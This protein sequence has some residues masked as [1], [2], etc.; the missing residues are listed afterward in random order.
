MRWE[1]PG[2]EFEEIYRETQ[3][4]YHEK[5][6][7]IYGAGMMGGRIYDAIVRVSQISVVAYLDRDV[8]KKE[9][10]GLPVFH[11]QDDWKKFGEDKSVMI[12]IALPDETGADVKKDLISRCGVR[13]D[14]CKLYSEFVMHDFPILMLYQNNKVFL[15]TVSLIVTE[16]CTLKCKHCAIMLPYFEQIHEYSFQKLADETDALFKNVDFIGNYTLTGGEPFLYKEL[17]RL[18]QYTGERY[19]DRIGSFK[20]ITNGTIVPGEEMLGLMRRFDMAV[21][22]SDY[23]NGVPALKPRLE[24]VLEVL[25]SSEIKTYLLSSSKWV[26]FGFNT[27]DHQYSHGQ[28]RDFFDYCHTRC[29]GYVDGK[30][31][32]CI[33]A[34]FAERTLYEKEDE[35]NT[36]DIVSGN[37]S[38]EW[39]RKLVE[40][41]LGYNSEG[42]LDMCQHC[43]G[44]VEVNQHYI[45]VGEQWTG[46]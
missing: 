26:D 32:Y 5:R 11:S 12:L 43:N 20:I 36:F 1:K 14:S 39:R 22:I 7:V 2:H 4:V 8:Q 34:Y 13:S 18:I 35:K 46:R 37:A 3:T 19:R 38:K 29:R 33:N 44:T 23:T 16:Q 10:R 15:D 17:Y 25:K 6:M 24:Q 28:L 45:E 40:F 42:F 30:I 31:R 41:D 27:V 9:Y 21:E